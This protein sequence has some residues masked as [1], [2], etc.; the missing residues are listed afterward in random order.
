MWGQYHL[1]V[2]FNDN[3]DCKSLESSSFPSIVV[4]V[5]QC[6]TSQLWTYLQ[7][8]MQKKRGEYYQ[9]IIHLLC[10]SIKNRTFSY[11]ILHMIV[12][13]KE[14]YAALYYVS[15]LRWWKTLIADVGKVF[16]FNCCHC[17]TRKELFA[18]LKKLGCETLLKRILKCLSCLLS[19]PI[20]LGVNCQVLWGFGA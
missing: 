5:R 12:P 19:V 3:F 17:L 2:I 13:K 11:Y 20:L 18:Q 7:R 1:C 15:V 16:L 4:I 6:K 10:M 9:V 8:W 14:L